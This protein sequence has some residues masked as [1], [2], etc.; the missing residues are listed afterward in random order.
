M[1]QVDLGVH[2]VLR[3]SIDSSHTFSFD[4]LN[5]PSKRTSRFTRSGNYEAT[6]ERRHS[7]GTPLSV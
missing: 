1:R 7:P 2:A 5:A 4:T 6:E 3:D